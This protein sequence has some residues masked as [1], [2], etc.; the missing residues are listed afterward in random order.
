M[1][2]RLMDDETAA[3]VRA[4]GYPIE[5]IPGAGWRIAWERVGRAPDD[6]RVVWE[7]RGGGDEGSSHRVAVSG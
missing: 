4:A 3:R 1:P 5:E 2:Q 7:L 6:W